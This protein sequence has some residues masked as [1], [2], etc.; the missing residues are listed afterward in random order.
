M[1]AS[2]Y[3]HTALMV[4]KNPDENENLGSVVPKNNNS[5]RLAKQ[6]RLG[7]CE[8]D[9]DIGSEVVQI[10]STSS[11]ICDELTVQEWHMNIE[12]CSPINA[13]LNFEY[14]WFASTTGTCDPGAIYSISGEVGGP[15]W[16][17]I[18]D[19]LYAT[20]SGSIGYSA[21]DGSNVNAAKSKGV[22]FGK[23][24]SSDGTIDGGVT[25]AIT[26]DL[27]VFEISLSLTLTCS[28]ADTS[29][30]IVIYDVEATLKVGSDSY[31]AGLTAKFIPAVTGSY[32]AWTISFYFIYG[33]WAVWQHDDAYKLSDWTVNGYLVS[34]N[35]DDD[36][37]CGR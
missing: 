14:Q 25:F 5:R 27:S 6:R 13:F 12:L 8:W 20:I 7:K 18:P 1:G 2:P 23:G 28:L 22:T 17:F 9:F 24:G 3:W 21:R 30:G 31:Y 11:N 29:R 35:C 32:E 34:N 26:L 37:Y 15:K 4:N 36:D 16:Y 10:D 33:Y 19:L